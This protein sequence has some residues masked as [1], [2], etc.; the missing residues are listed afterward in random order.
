MKTEIIP[1]N[2]YFVLM[3]IETGEEL[4]VLETRKEAE[5]AQ[6]DYEENYIKNKS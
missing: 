6:K 3:L 1:E 4:D 2:E 5:I